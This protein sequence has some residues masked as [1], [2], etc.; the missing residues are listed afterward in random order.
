MFK[1]ERAKQMLCLRQQGKTYQ[2]IGDLFGVTRQRVYDIINHEHKYKGRLRK[3]TYDIE[4]IK[5]KGLYELFKKDLTL[6]TYKLGKII[7][8]KENI[9]SSYRSKIIPLLEKEKEVNLKIKQIK[10]LIEYS[11][12][13]FEELFQEREV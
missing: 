2:E 4:K 13:T 10:N 3:S 11:G 6:T 5:Y 9:S 1:E 8:G 12:M 7:F